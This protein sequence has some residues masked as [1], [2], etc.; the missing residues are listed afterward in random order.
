M[1]DD[2]LH[3]FFWRVRRRKWSCVD[4]M[5][6]S[7][8]ILLSRVWFVVH[9]SSGTSCCTGTRRILNIPGWHRRAQSEIPVR[10]IRWTE[11]KILRINAW[12]RRWIDR[13]KL[14][15]IEKPDAVSMGV[16]LDSVVSFKSPLLAE[17]CRAVV[18]AELLNAV[19]DDVAIWVLLIR[20]WGCPTVE[21]FQAVP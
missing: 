5:L 8:S 9:G 11:L 4:G 1:A 15:D 16:Y 13:T 3:L 12:T 18:E 14:L 19:D 10:A 6:T 21:L 20:C 17:W 7:S 2:S